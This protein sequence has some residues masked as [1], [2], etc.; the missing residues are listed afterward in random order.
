MN[1]KEFSK[2]LLFQ[3]SIL[4]WIITIS[5]IILAFVCV[6]YGYT[7]SLPW[8]SVIPGLSWAAYGVS[9]GFYYNKA[10]KENTRDGIKFETVMTELNQEPIVPSIENTDD[11]NIDYGI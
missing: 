10:K 5:Y 3:E 6:K 8:L 1:K 7:G 4:I 2:A 9:Q 11:I